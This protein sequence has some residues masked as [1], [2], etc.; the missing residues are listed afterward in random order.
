MTLNS[1]KKGILISTLLL[2]A[3]YLLAQEYQ[4]GTPKLKGPG[5]PG[6]SASVTVSPDGSAV[7]IIF[8]RFQIWKK[9]GNYSASQLKTFCEFIIPLSVKPGYL[10]EA[11]YVDYRG[12]MDVPEVGNAT[13]ITSGPLLEFRHR[14]G[15]DNKITTFLGG[16]VQDIFVRHEVPQVKRSACQEQTA[17]RFMTQLSFAVPNMRGILKLKRESGVIIDSADVAVGEAPISI[18]LRVVRCK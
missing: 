9:K 7:S 10:I 3:P 11:G 13:I 12:F 17:I 4:L 6:N 16:G 1:I 14:Q 5:C 18:G 15:N 2:A 8:D